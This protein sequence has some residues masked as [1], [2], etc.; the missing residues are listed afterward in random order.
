MHIITASLRDS[1]LPSRR[2]FLGGASALLVESMLSE[3]RAEP[4]M[5]QPREKNPDV[6]PGQQ[7]RGLGPNPT[8]DAM[9]KFAADGKAKPFA[10]NTVIAHLPA[11]GLFRDGTIRLHNALSESSFAHKLA[12]LP[13]E[14]YHMTI[15]NGSNDLGRPDS[16]WPGGVPIEAP[17]EECNRI[18]LQRMKSC[19]LRA[20][21]PIEVSIDV[22]QTLDY[23]RACTLRMR[24]ASPDAGRNLRAIRDQLA[25]VYRV[26]VLPNDTYGFHITIA[27]TM[28]DFSEQE[29][30]EYTKLLQ[31]QLPD[32]VKLAPT[33]ELG[34][35]EYCTFPNMYRF[36]VQHLLRVV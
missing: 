3:A 32:L 12:I 26:P 17:I 28:Q 31:Q 2:S 20:Q 35:A 13:P 23:G 18:M 6:I 29:H 24:G 11:Q 19:Q 36:D 33:L 7:D 15:F 16:T 5:Q 8:A 10:G 22:D 30:A 21:F 27:Y 34:L 9:L 1:S 25:A 4:F 14:S